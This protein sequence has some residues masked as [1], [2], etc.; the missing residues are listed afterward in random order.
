[1]NA[2]ALLG[3]DLGKQVF[4]LHGQDARG[5]QVLRKR[6]NRAQLLPFLAQ[7]PPCIVAMES[8][9]G[10][11]WL[12]R[13]ARSYGHRMRLIA[14]QHVKPYVI[15]NKNDYR[16]AEGICETACRPKPATSR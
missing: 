10:A 5:H 8:C 13:Q 7:L 15:G 9:G 11:H 14:P 2:L 6:L 12:A 1:M 16:D 4:H 3:I